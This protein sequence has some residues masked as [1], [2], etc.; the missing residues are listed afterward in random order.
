MPPFPPQP[1]TLHPNQ[2]PTEVA[3]SP[4][5]H[6]AH[7]A[8]GEVLPLLP[9]HPDLQSG[10][11]G[12]ANAARGPSGAGQGGGQNTPRRLGHAVRVD[13]G[14]AQQ[15]QERGREAARPAGRREQGRP[16]CAQAASCTEAAWLARLPLACPAASSST[17]AAAV[18]PPPAPLPRHLPPL[19]SLSPTCSRAALSA[20]EV[21]AAPDRTKRSEGMP[22]PCMVHR[23]PGGRVVPAGCASVQTGGCMPLVRE[24]ASLTRGSSTQRPPLLLPQPRRPLGPPGGHPTPHPP[25]LCQHRWVLQQRAQQGGHCGEPCH[26]AFAQQGGKRERVPA[27]GQHHAAAGG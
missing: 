3:L 4:E 20:G 7:P 26:A 8:G 15:L 25:H 11:D 13:K 1:R 5:A 18:T 22:P 27:G 9:H 23:G 19:P 17:A 14:H 24:A 21:E 12:Q 2:Q 16:S 6:L 10:G